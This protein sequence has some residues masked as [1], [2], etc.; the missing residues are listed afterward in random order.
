MPLLIALFVI[1][2]LLALFAAVWIFSDGDLYGA[3]YGNDDGGE[4]T[5]NVVA[6]NDASSGATF[7]ID[8]KESGKLSLGTQSV[9]V[10]G[11]KHELNAI[12]DGKE[13]RRT[14]YP[15]FFW[16]VDFERNGIHPD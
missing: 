5:L 16:I 1:I 10:L 9:P 2:V 11:R 4:Y 15:G 8:G 12:K 13:L 6:A 7:Y 3:V 14:V